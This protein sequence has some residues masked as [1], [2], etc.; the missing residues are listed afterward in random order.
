MPDIWLQPVQGQDDLL[1]LSQTLL[2]AFRVCQVQ[3]QQFFIAIELIGHSAAGDLDPSPLQ[4]LMDL[5]NAPL[6]LIA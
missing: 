5:R 2:Q 4:F 3:R 1:L 6:F